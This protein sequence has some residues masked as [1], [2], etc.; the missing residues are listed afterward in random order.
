MAEGGTPDILFNLNI[1]N[2]GIKDAYEN[3]VT[4]KQIAPMAKYVEGK[5]NSSLSMTT[6]LDSKM[7]PVWDSFNGKGSLNIPNASVKGFKPF[8]VVGDKLNI[9]ELQN[10]ALNNVN[11]TFTITKGRFY[12]SPFSYTVLGNKVT[13]S[14]SN[15]LDKSIDYV[16]SVNVPASKLKNQGNKAISSLLGKNVNLITANSVEV[17]ANIKGTVDSPTVTTSAGNIIK[18]TK[19]QVTQE[20][21]KEV[22]KQIEQ[23]KEEVKK[24]VQTKVDTVK[25]KVEEKVKDKLK[26]LFK[27]K[28]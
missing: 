21:K 17:N 7:M 12:V 19:K 9:K 11:T 27:K 2:L 16:M 24:E 3:F 23:K 22:N 15:G 6:K 4:V 13:L 14:G 28:F 18:D 26:D 25:K 5:F 8:E 10:P 20:V 1:K